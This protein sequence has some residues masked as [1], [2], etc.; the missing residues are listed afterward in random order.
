[1]LLLPTGVLRLLPR[2]PVAA[3]VARGPCFGLRRAGLRRDGNW[4]REELQ[5]LVGQT[6][7][8]SSGGSDG[9]DGKDE[10]AG[11]VWHEE[12]NA[13]GRKYFRNPKSGARSWD[14]PSSGVVKSLVELELEAEQSGGVRE[15]MSFGGGVDATS[16]MVRV[17]ENFWQVVD[18]ARKGYWVG[19]V[20]CGAWI[21][22]EL[23]KL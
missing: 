6:R 21:A 17:V 16:L 7:A 11:D 8:A 20:G 12:R 2:A 9:R 23:F 4:R 3:L 22:Y 1:M 5:L 19:I 10:S 15:N 18:F 14:R 13:Q